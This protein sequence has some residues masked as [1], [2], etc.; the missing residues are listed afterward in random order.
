MIIT[1]LSLKK[2][3]YKVHY[4][5]FSIVGICIASAFHYRSMKL[6]FFTYH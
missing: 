6:F 2:V 4:L 1:L 5:N 3:K